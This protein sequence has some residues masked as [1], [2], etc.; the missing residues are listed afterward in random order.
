MGN[1]K[2]KLVLHAVVGLAL[3]SG[4]TLGGPTEDAFAQRTAGQPQEFA[5]GLADLDEATKV[6]LTANSA[7]NLATVIELCESAI[8][9]GL[10]EVDEKWAKQLLAGTRFERASAFSSMIFDSKPVDRRWTQFREVAV[11]DLVMAL[12][13]EPNSAEMHL[14]LGRLYTLPGRKGHREKAIE[15]LDRAIEL[16]NEDPRLQSKAYAYRAGVQ[17]D[18]AKRAED[19]NKSIELDSKNIEAIRTRAM[20]RIELGENDEAIA[21]LERAIELDPT[22]AQTYETLA[23]VQ[24]ALGSSED[25]IATLG[26]AI[27]LAPD[28]PSSY[29]QRARIYLQLGKGELALKDSQQALKMVPRNTGVLMQHAQILHQQDR[30]KEAL[31]LVTRLLIANPGLTDAIELRA[32]LLAEE[33]RFKEAIADLE[34]AVEQN[35][36]AQ[37]LLG[38]LG[39]LYA[40]NKQAEKAIE[41]YDRLIEQGL[42]MGVIYRNRA[43]ALLSLNRQAEALADYQ[44]ALEMAPEDAGVLN[45]LAWLMATSPDESLRDGKEAIELASKACELTEY[46]KAYILSTLAAAH[47]EAGDFDAARE[48]AQKAVE[49][50]GDDVLDQLKAELESYRRNEPWRENHGNE[51]EATD[52]PQVDDVDGEKPAS[53]T[54]VSETSSAK[55]SDDLPRVPL[56]TDSKSPSRKKDNPLPNEDFRPPTKSD[57]SEETDKPEKTDEEAA[58]SGKETANKEDPDKKDTDADDADKE[59]EDADSGDD[60]P[61]KEESENEG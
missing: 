50:S 44:T 17:Q 39:A 40:A 27:E 56:P 25:A 11:A 29:A 48:W 12:K 51:K 13:I 16:G 52:A 31:R 36:E 32:R 2:R 19:L 55:S 53:D 18:K 54:S 33:G 8:R 47:A 45:N 1:R 49:L 14:L 9:K 26:R 37:Q 60:D 23:L 58:E 5:P 61:N 43:D 46:K 38:T 3:V 21:D 30:T 34:K 42:K 4:L 59:S 41:A 10:G 22:A 15:S 6:K 7:Q 28:E 35:P 24:H 57:P 20:I